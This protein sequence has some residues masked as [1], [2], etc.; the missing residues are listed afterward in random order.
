MSSKIEKRRSPSQGMRR[1]WI[2]APSLRGGSFCA[3]RGLAVPD[4]VVHRDSTAVFLFETAYTDNVKRRDT[5]ALWEKDPG[6]IGGS[7]K[8]YHG[9]ADSMGQN[10]QNMKRNS[11]ELLEI[12][13]KTKTM[14]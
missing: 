14:L 1:V 3:W 10:N 4:R 11:H 13:T 2:C 9:L 7:L 12:L 6:S 5:P 8:K